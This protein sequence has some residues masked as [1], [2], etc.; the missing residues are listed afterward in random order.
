MAKKTLNTDAFDGTGNMD[1]KI[2]EW[3]DIYSNGYMPVKYLHKSICDLLKWNFFCF[4]DESIVTYIFVNH[5]WKYIQSTK[6]VNVRNSIFIIY[7][8]CEFGITGIK[9]QRYT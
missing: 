4:E 2:T 8:Q 5:I 7:I 9:S 3:F 6:K 1:V